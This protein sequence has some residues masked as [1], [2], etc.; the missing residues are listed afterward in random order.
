MDK[1]LTIGEASRILGISVDTL[2]RWSDDGKVTVLVLPSGHRRYRQ[3]DIEA[4][5]KAVS[6]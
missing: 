5:T 3:A 1:L 2:R 6:E 4:L